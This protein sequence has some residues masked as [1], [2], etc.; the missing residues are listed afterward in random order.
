MNRLLPR[1][2]Y[3]YETSHWLGEPQLG[4]VLACSD[5]QLTMFDLNINTILLFLV[6]D[7]VMESNSK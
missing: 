7:I 3:P 2:E 4:M 1:F 5:A 6:L